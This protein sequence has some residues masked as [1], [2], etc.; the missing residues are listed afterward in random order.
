[1][2]LLFVD[3][4]FLY[5]GEGKGIEKQAKSCIALLYQFK[6]F[7][8]GNQGK[9]YWVIFMPMQIVILDRTVGEICIVP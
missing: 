8:L 9:K 3:P 7:D 6:K 4:K 5:S 1:M 2:I